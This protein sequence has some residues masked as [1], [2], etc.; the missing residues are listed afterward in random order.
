MSG[1]PLSPRSNIRSL[2]NDVQSAINLRLSPSS[3][4]LLQSPS[5]T[6]QTH[7]MS[8]LLLSKIYWNRQ[9][10][11]SN[12]Q[13]ITCVCL[14]NLPCSS[15]SSA[16]SSTR[17]LINASF[18]IIDVHVN[19]RTVTFLSFLLL[20][21][22]FHHECFSPVLVAVSGPSVASPETLRPHLIKSAND[23]LSDIKKPAPV[24][25]HLRSIERDAS[26]SSSLE[27]CQWMGDSF[28]R[29][30]Q[31]RSNGRS[32]DLRNCLQGWSSSAW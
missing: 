1:S 7:H 21:D 26:S 20:I 29:F 10:R 6:T 22:G 16:S 8:Q 31:S 32:R 17:C 18:F 14:I 5:P 23:S 13:L 30:A 19:R 9:Q 28:G 25:E 12:T 24:S 4:S 15:S 27:T 11:L 3:N 2:S